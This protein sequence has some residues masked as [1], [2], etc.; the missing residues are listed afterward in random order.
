MMK[1]TEL[2]NGSKSKNINTKSK[3]VMENRRLDEGKK[4]YDDGQE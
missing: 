4:A 1:V 2:K 3:G